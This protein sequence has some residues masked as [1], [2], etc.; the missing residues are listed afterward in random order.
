MVRLFGFRQADGVITEIVDAI[1]S[2]QEG[3]TEDSEGAY[4][5][6]EIHSHEA[7][8]TRTLDFQDVVIGSDG[9]VVASESEGEVW[10]RI[11][12]LA[13]NSVLAIERLLGTNFLV[14][15]ETVSSASQSA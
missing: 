13:L 10:K 2:A 9:E 6:G 7:T 5:L 15:K 3:I 1:P 14:T 11:T 4:R 12:L 8:D